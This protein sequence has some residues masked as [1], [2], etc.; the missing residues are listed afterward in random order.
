MYCYITFYKG[1][2]YP[3]SSDI[4]ADNDVVASV[5]IYPNKLI[6]ISLPSL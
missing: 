2:T 5:F 1:K 3:H 4:M 6:I